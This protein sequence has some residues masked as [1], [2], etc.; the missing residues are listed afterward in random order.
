MTRFLVRIGL[1][2]GLTL[3]VFG[4]P[5]GAE[6]IVAG[7]TVLP[8]IA[9]QD[10]TLLPGTP[11]N[12]GPSPILIK[13]VTGVGE[14]TINRDTQVGNTIPIASLSG[15]MFYGSNPLLGSY[16]FGN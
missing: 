14:I 2:F 5:A 3:A 11:F 7:S 6:P 10:I 1:A 8:G 13:D 16:V 15:G 9:I 12:P 4:V